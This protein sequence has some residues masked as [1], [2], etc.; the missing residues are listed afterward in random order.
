MVH[1]VLDLDCLGIAGQFGEIL[2]DGIVQRQLTFQAGQR[3]GG[4]GKLLGG[5]GNVIN[6]SWR[7]GYLQFQAGHAITLLE[8]HLP[9]LINTHRTTGGV[10]VVIRLEYFIDGRI[11][12]G[13]CQ[14]GKK[15]NT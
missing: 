11:L 12:A 2:A 4:S 9:I 14:G 10:S 1:Q 5:G 3:Y 13:A 6:A 15:C 8:C 7:V